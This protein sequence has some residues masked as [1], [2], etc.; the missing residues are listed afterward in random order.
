MMMAIR[1]ARASANSSKI[2]FCGYHGWHDWYLSTNLQNKKNLNKHLLIGL[3]TRGVPKELINTVY[4]FEFNS[5]ESLKKILH[6]NK[7]IKIIVIE[8]ARKTTID[9][10]MSLYLNHLK[11]NKEMIIILDEI[12]S[13]LRT[14]I[15]GVYSLIKLI[16]SMV[17]YGKAL[18]NGFAIN[19]IVGDEIMENSLNTFISSTFHTERVGF[20]AAIKTLEII[21]REKLWLQLNTIG[22]RV[23]KGYNNIAKT[24]NIDLSTN[25]FYPLPF[26]DFNYRK[27]KLVFNIRYSR[28]FKKKYIGS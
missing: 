19:A 5:V 14:S 12:T 24:N 16:P 27:K 15:T 22:K 26:F 20:V 28:T 9:K 6:K 4:P 13:G 18:G 7:S 25:D 2:A 10:K 11:K 17:V 8:G 3:K 21:N 1:I 23:V